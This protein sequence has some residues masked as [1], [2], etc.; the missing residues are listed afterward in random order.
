MGWVLMYHNVHVEVKR[1]L[2]GIWFSLHQVPLCPPFQPC[3]TGNDG[4][5]SSHRAASDM[6]T[7]SVHQE[8]LS[9]AASG[10]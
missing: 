4:S 9:A 3:V 2:R 1:Q 5:R 7:P 6:A 8:S 10:S